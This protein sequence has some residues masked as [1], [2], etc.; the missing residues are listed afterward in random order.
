MPAAVSIDPR[1]ERLA[2]MQAIRDALTRFCRGMDRGDVSLAKSAFHEDAHEEHGPVVG[3]AHKLLD[4]MIPM[5]KTSYERLVRNI[6]NLSVEVDGDSALSEANWSGIMRDS[7]NDM[8]HQ[9]RYL[10]RWE[11]RA[12]EWKIAAR[13][14]LI[15][16]WRL[17]VRNANPFVADAE[18]M[19]K[20]AGRGFED[21]EVRAALGLTERS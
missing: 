9:G 12:G 3:N 17:E 21:V 5:L 10:D 15:D 18:A 1:F 4:T 20:F 16:W 8:F 19:L 2:D 7:V 6:G 11:R 13:V 14:S